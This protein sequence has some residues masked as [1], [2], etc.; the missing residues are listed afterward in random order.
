MKARQMECLERALEAEYQNLPD[1]INLETVRGEYG[2]L[3]SHYEN[4]V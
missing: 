1:V 4:L 2:K 3:L